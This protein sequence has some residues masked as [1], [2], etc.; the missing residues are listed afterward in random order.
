MRFVHYKFIF[1]KHLMCKYGFSLKAAR[2]E[3]DSWLEVL[4]DNISYETPKLDAEEC[5]S[6]Y[7]D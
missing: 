3:L 4:G 6:Y 7:N 1:I 2:N 5:I